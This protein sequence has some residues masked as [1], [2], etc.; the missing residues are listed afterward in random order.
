MIGRAIATQHRADIVAAGITE[1]PAGF[2]MILDADDLAGET[3]TVEARLASTG[4]QLDGSPL[5]IALPLPAD[6]IAERRITNARY[7]FARPLEAVGGEHAIFVAYAPTGMLQPFVRRFLRLLADQD[8]AVSL[9]INADRPVLLDD[10]LLASVASAMVRDNRGYD[11]GAWA[12]ML[13]VAPQLYGARSLYIINDSIFG[14]TTEAAFGEAIAALRA[15][16]ADLAGLSETLERGWHIQ[17]YFLR[18]SADLLSSYAFQLFVNSVHVVS[19]KDEVI[20]AFEVPLTTRICDA[21]FTADAV[22]KVDEARNPTLFAWRRLLDAGFPFVKLLLLRGRFPHISTKGLG[23][24][25]RH[26]GFDRQLLDATLD[27]GTDEPQPD[28]EFPLLARVR[29]SSRDDDPVPTKPYK[30]AFFGPW[31][32]DNGL[33]SA[34]RGIISAIRNTGVRLNLYPIRKPFH[35]HK[36][37]TPPLDVIDFDGPADIAIVHLNPDSWHLLTDDQRGEIA[38]AGRRIGYWVWEMEHLPPAWRR[39]FSSVDRIWAPSGFN[40]ALFE[41]QDEAPVDVIPHLVPVTHDAPNGGDAI[42]NALGLPTDRRLILYVFDGAS[43]LVRKNPAALLR[44]FEASGLAERG[45]SLVLKTKNL[46]DRP[47]DGRAL[48]KQAAAIDD[49]VLL[50][51]SLD[52]HELHDLVAA[53]DIYAS[54]H[55]AE[56]FGLTVA[57]AMATGRTVVATDYSGTMQFLDD[58]CGFPVK[59]N[60]WTLDEDFGHYTMGGTW[61][62]IDENALADALVKATVLIDAGDTSIGDAARSRIAT[63][64]SIETIG[65][66][67]GASF[68]DV[69]RQSRDIRRMP[70]RI[71]EGATGVPLA[72]FEPGPGLSVVPLKAG[73]L[74]PKEQWPGEIS[75]RSDEWILFVPEDCGLHPLTQ[76][77]LMRQVAARPDVAI[78]YADDAAFGAPTL[79]EQVRLKPH[80]DRTMFA[81]QDYIG[82]PLFVR[83]SV[84]HELGGW[85][86][87]QGDAALY[88]LVLRAAE[89]GR[90]IDRIPEVLVVTTGKRVIAPRD[91]R[92]RLI[93]R[94]PLYAAYH[95]VDGPTQESLHL[96]PRLNGDLPPVTLCVP[97]RRSVIEGG[98]G[99]YVER[100]LDSLKDVDWPFDRLTV[101]IGD[102]VIGEPTWERADWPFTVRRIETPR[103]PDE[104]FN[105]SAKMNQLWRAADSEIVL[106]VNDDIVA[107][108]R[109]WLRALVGFAVDRDI[110]AV[111][112]R[113]LF[114][115][116]TVQH[117]G[118][119]GGVMGTSVHA[120]LGRRAGAATYM[121]WAVTQRELSMVTGAMI[122]TRRSV[123]EAVGGFDERFT[124]E[125][126]DVDLCLKI[127]QLGLRIVYNPVAELIHSEK[128]SRGE[129]AP[130][131]EQL[132][133]FLSRW[134]DWL[135]DDPALPPNMRRDMLDLAPAAGPGSWFV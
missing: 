132:A 63:T 56:G 52:T 3:I 39:D 5:T 122:A 33:G 130:S 8:I 22:F 75:D 16:P 99:T 81:A 20:N 84:L 19:D 1:G 25:L 105:F 134:Q 10:D 53:C 88:D 120:W 27:Y 30:V 79:I 55:C 131:G 127:R 113:L 72:S 90:S 95:A 34:S 111:G 114:D 42:R 47:G 17:S 4:E 61:G 51:R 86:T 107:T 18:I 96:K 48:A 103:T 32:Y 62:R 69:V 101:L 126:N 65:A 41:A 112:A 60:R 67:I 38:R 40:A 73:T 2:T 97:T 133:L 78:F 117:A 85:D 50:D 92:R 64:L 26:A 58:S 123:L 119:Y 135:S 87:A 36:P 21:G 49:V 125:F 104:P 108:Q 45:W 124:L 43:Y 93:D 7:T 91:I 24:A 28:G 54:P 44:A 9:V 83:A 109:N 118:I 68:D 129:L 14:P 121:D 98:V 74:K 35:V 6:Q 115:D 77:L 31:N 23:K 46:M 57:E 89:Q 12:H 13:R 116:G 100:L 82:V 110:G 128:K 37:L 80:F 59:A 15:N 66:A 106:L 102:D 29:P 94:S 11:F 76:R 71:E 70:P